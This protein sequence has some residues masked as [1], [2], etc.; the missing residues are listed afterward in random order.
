MD[1]KEIIVNTT[2]CLIRL[3]IGII[4]SP[5]ECGIESLG[6]ISHGVNTEVIMTYEF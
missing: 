5:V 6:S 3:R 2:N 1:L 4:E